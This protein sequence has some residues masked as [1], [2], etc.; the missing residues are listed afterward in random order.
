MGCGGGIARRRSH[1][2]GVRRS[3]RRRPGRGCAC[4]QPQ[5]LRDVSRAGSHRTQASTRRPSRLCW[6][7]IEELKAWAP[8][9][10]EQVVWDRNMPIGNDTGMTEEERAPA[11]ALDRDTEIGMSRARNDCSA[12]LPPPTT[13]RLEAVE[14]QHQAR[15]GTITSARRDAR[16]PDD[17]RRPAQGA[18]FLRR[19]S[20]SQIAARSR[21]SP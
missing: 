6:K 18:E 7:S 10:L 15:R 9:I 12:D 3:C 20:N 2:G 4:G 8:K 13:L 14:L 1:L 21:P 17:R 5:A 16:R 11:G 19:R